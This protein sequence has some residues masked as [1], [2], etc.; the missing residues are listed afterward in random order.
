MVSCKFNS[1]WQGGCWENIVMMLFLRD[2]NFGERD[3]GVNPPWRSRL[4]TVFSLSHEGAIASDELDER[5]PPQELLSPDAVIFLHALNPDSRHKWVDWFTNVDTSSTR[6]HLVIV[7]RD[8]G[9]THDPKWM[10]GVHAC[11]WG[12]GHFSPNSQN[13]SVRE[14][15]AEFQRGV[16]RPDLLQP[17]LMPEA[18]L[19]YALAIHYGLD[20]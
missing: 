18:V 14:F 1:L 20:L 11:Y 5:T 13:E 2:H 8:G 19:A 9:V 4:E 17:R 7:A 3:F 6:G 16:F 15:V 12:L 10:S